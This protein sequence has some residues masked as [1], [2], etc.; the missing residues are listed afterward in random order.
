MR[1]N[2]SA[3]VAGSRT[4]VL[5]AATGVNRHTAR[6]T[7]PDPWSGSANCCLAEG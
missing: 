6:C 5:I 4:P 1:Q 2:A 3:A 7:S